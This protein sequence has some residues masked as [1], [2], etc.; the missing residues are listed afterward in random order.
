MTPKY[1]RMIDRMKKQE[2]NR[3]QRPS[4]V[5]KNWSVYIVR[6]SD[7][8]LYTGT[9][10]DLDRRLKMH[11]AGRGAKYTKT[12]RPVTVVYQR[13]RMTRSVALIKE[14]AIKS[15]SKKDKEALVTS[16]ISKK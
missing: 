7:G 6:C 5:L 10:N 13:K 2:E 15:L 4:L 16:T 8:S 9:T 1:K 12:R 11:N 3:G 14:C